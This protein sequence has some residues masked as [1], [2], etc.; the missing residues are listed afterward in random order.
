MDDLGK[1]V[2]DLVCLMEIE[3]G[4][5]DW[6]WGWNILEVVLENLDL[7]K[8]YLTVSRLRHQKIRNVSG[9]LDYLLKCWKKVFKF[10][11]QFK[12]TYPKLP[13]K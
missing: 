5:L 11:N 9:R 6:V 12:S 8:N 13:N 10:N 1:M 4:T 2:F 3:F 7:S